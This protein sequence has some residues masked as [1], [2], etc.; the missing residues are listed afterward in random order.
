MEGKGDVDLWF[1]RE[2]PQHLMGRMMGAGGQ[3]WKLRG[4]FNVRCKA[5]STN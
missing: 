1:Q 2:N 5:E 3:S 4:Q